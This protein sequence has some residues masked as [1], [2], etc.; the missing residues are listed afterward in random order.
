MA[1]VQDDGKFRNIMLVV[2]SVGI[3]SSIIFHL[4]VKEVKDEENI[5]LLP[6]NKTNLPGLKQKDFVV[7]MTVKN[8]LAEPQFYQVIQT[9]HLKDMECIVQLTAID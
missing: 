7:P 9:Q 5:S 4:S 6:H 3:I 8:W 1:C 2:I